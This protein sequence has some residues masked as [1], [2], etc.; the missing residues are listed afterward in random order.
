[1]LTLNPKKRI[2]AEEALKVPW[3]CNRQSVALA[4]HRQ[5]TVDCLK[6]FNARRKLKVGLSLK[7]SILIRFLFDK[8]TDSRY[9][10]Y[11]YVLSLS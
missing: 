5:D 7:L 11:V 2:T 8:H 4:V 3:I 6:Q 9:L 10:K 1:M